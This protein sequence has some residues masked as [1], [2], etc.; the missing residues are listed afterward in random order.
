MQPHFACCGRDRRREEGSEWGERERGV[1]RERVINNTA[2]ALER[3]KMLQPSITPPVC[4]DKLAS[5]I[6]ASLLFSLT[7]VTNRSML[8]MRKNSLSNSS[9]FDSPEFLDGSLKIPV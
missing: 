1:E 7:A 3:E 6:R 4:F 2:L 5:T 9:I 8:P